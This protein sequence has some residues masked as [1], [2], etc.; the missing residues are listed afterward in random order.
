VCCSVLQCV[1]VCCSVL[2][3]VAVCCSELQC[4]AVC[5]SMLQYVAVCCNELQCVTVCCSVL[6]FVA[7]CCSMLQCVAMWSCNLANYVARGVCVWVYMSGYVSISASVF[8]EFCQ[9]ELY[10]CVWN[11]ARFSTKFLS[12]FRGRNSQISPRQTNHYWM[13][14]VLTF[15]NLWGSNRDAQKQNCSQKLALLSFYI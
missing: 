1:A 5:C 9:I 3:C 2:Q 14:I 15:E 10:K 12:M 4:V 7:G 13:I 11:F 6:Q 8:A